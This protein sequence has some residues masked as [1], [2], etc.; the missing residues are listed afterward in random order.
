M[1]SEETGIVR[2]EWRGE[3]RKV[4]EGITP[5]EG[6]TTSEAL[7]V[8][9]FI[10]SGGNGEGAARDA[11]PHLKG[12]SGAEKACTLLTKP[13]V[14]AA[15]NASLVANGFSKEAVVNKFAQLAHHGQSEKTQVAANREL[16]RILRL[17]GDE[18]GGAGV[19]VQVNFSL[20]GSPRA[21]S[22]PIDAEFKEKDG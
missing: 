20:P 10:K 2:T 7:F 13:Y 8:V 16:G 11:F 12:R 6:L 21:K 1:V 9:A 14:K 19:N 22:E 18:E 17:Y 3:K 4:R 15:I 5:F